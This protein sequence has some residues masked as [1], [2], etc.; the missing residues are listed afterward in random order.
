M[1]PEPMSRTL[2]RTLTRIATRRA[3]S[4]L[5]E[6]DQYPSGLTFKLILNPYGP[7]Q[8]VSYVTELKQYP[9]GLIRGSETW[10]SN[11]IDW[12]YSSHLSLMSFSS[13]VVQITK[14][15]GNIQQYPYGTFTDSG[16]G[17]YYSLG[18]PDNM[19]SFVAC[20]EKQ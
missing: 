3:S 11:T 6:L 10:I 18:R 15:T 12:E 2:T 7:G 8:D 9:Y 19:L 5:T 13:Y 17:Q 14:E 1:W 4:T 16:S 20:N